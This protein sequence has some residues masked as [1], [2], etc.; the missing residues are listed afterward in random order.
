MRPFAIFLT[1][2]ALLATGCGGADSQQAAKPAK[3]KPQAPSE[4][5]GGVAA[6]CLA[7]FNWKGRLYAR[8]AGELEKPFQTGE[9]LGHGVEPGCNDMGEYREPDKDV[10][11]VRIKGV[12]PEIA[13]GRLGDD[14]PYFNVMPAS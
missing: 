14:R 9:E 4:P 3:P 7:G 2:L 6:S 10:T 1:L 8:G 5:G 11:V 13:V 12:D